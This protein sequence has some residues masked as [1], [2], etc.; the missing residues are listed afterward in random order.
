ML[1]NEALR[2]VREHLGVPHYTSFFELV[3][4]VESFF[5]CEGNKEIRQ[6]P[7]CQNFYAISLLNAAGLPLNEA[8]GIYWLREAASQGFPKAQYNLSRHYE[9]GLGVTQDFGKAYELCEAAAAQGYDD[10]VSRL[11]YIRRKHRSHLAMMKTAEQLGSD[12]R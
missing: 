10:A 7:L 8:K 1:E 2:H 9:D 4:F 6:C 12:D 11:P 5:E 3:L